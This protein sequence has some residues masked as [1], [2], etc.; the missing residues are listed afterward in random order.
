MQKL[1][2][3][4]IK[5]FNMKNKQLKTKLQYEYYNY[6]LDHMRVYLCVPT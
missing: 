5:L 2:K 4:E 3:N 6:N 1:L